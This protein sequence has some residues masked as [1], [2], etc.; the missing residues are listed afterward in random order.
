MSC[1]LHAA[2]RVF[3]VDAFLG[4]SSLQ[5]ELI[6]KRG[7][8]V[9]GQQPRSA[10]GFKLDVS[11]ADSGDLDG[12]IS[13]AIVFLDENEEELRRLGA[14]EGVEAVS[15]EFGVRSRAGLVQS[16]TFP[17]ELLWRAGALDVAL[18]VSH[19]PTADAIH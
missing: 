8:P 2:G 5:P 18:T 7:D 3:D 19:Y 16:H 14:F 6:Y 15:L 4:E 1:A 17:P 10:S 13:D 11:L 9:P 12:Q